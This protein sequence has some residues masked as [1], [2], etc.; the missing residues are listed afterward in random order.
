M[1]HALQV[2]V[3]DRGLCR[4]ELQGGAIAAVEDIGACRDGELF[5]WS[6]LVDI[7]ING[8]AGVDFGDPALKP[9]ALIGI[10]EPLFS[11]GVTCFLPTLTTNRIDALARQFQLLEQ[12]RQE[13]LQFA[14][15]VPGYHLEGPWLS[16]GPSH[17]AHD[18]ALMRPPSW[19]DFE[20][21]QR[22]AGGRIRLVTLAPELDGA[23]AFIERATKAGVRCAVGHTDGNAHDIQQA[24]TAGA[25]VATHL[26]NGCPQKLD[27]H[28]APFWAQLAHDTLLPGLICDGFHLTSEMIK[29]VSRVKGLDRCCLVTDA[30][31]AALMPPGIYQIGTMQA[32]LLPSGQVVR[33]DRASMAGAALTMNRAVAHFQRATGCTLSAALTAASQVPL[34]AIGCPAG[35]HTFAPGSPA[36]LVL[37]EADENALTVRQTFLAGEMVWSG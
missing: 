34:Q 27:R 16:P 31:A 19:S 23:P 12:T 8:F 25:T 32:E 26:G 36:D 5:A 28:T 33:L 22:A 11:T 1:K 4:L 6:G 18:P 35:A 21:L 3:P 24:V 29:I 13:S 14:R 2:N 30:I 15:C 17:G 7:Q 9:N 37:F 20:E 10:L